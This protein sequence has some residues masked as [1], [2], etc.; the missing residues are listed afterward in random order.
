MF[1]YHVLTIIIFIGFS[2]IKL[3]YIIQILMPIKTFEVKLRSQKK[4]RGFLPAIFRCAFRAVFRVV[5]F[6]FHSLSVLCRRF[7]ICLS[8]IS[9]SGL[10][11]L[12]WNLRTLC[13]VR[14]NNTHARFSLYNPLLMD[15]TTI[16]AQLPLQPQPRTTLP[17][18]SSDY[19]ACFPPC[20]ARARMP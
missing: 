7:P 1:V 11:P 18:C 4:K 17:K 20:P 15:Y 12:Y 6:P 5:L 9:Y 10:T 14:T 13:A 16:T 19:G 8:S 3:S 2:S